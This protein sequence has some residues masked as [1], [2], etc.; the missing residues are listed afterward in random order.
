MHAITHPHTA[1][2]H[3]H[4][5]DRGIVF[6]WAW[7]AFCVFHI[8]RRISETGGTDPGLLYILATLCSLI[9]LLNPRWMPAF[10]LSVV[11][12][13]A[14]TLQT[15]PVNSNHTF[16][17]IFLL[18][19]M[20][21]ALASILLRRRR[22]LHMTPG[23]FYAAFAPYGKMMLVIMYF[24]GVFHKLNTDF[25]NPDTSCAVTLWELYPLPFGLADARWAH[26]LAIYAALIIEAAIIVML[27]VPRW[28]YAGVMLGLIFHFCL[29]V[30]GYRFFVAFSS[31]TFALHFLFL[32]EDFMARLRGSRLGRAAARHRWLYPALIF[33][34]LAAYM[35]VLTLDIASLYYATVAL[36]IVFTGSVIVG[37]GRYARSRVWRYEDSWRGLGGGT[38]LL[39]VLST[40]FFINCAMP[41]LGLKTQQN[42]NMFSNLT[43]ERGQTNHLLFGRPPYMFEFQNDLVRILR[44]NHPYF[45][46]V[47][48]EELLIPHL[49]FR[50]LIS[51]MPAEHLAALLVMYER[52]GVVHFITPDHVSDPEVLRPLSPWL[53]DWFHF[54]YV[55]TR[56]P[57]VCEADRFP[58]GREPVYK[59]RLKD[60]APTG[61][62]A[63][64]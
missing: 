31:M 33:A 51:T 42:L 58:Q 3:R 30:N 22:P 40:L 9:A 2:D 14:A 54:Q 36:F 49:E 24:Y 16:M 18:T 37:V 59:G 20:T 26:Y 1:A 56:G 39:H 5:D 38:P 17:R 64:D 52:D 8:A 27:F 55:P 4:L 45:R 6:I 12:G 32:P 28:K 47:R 15:M 11:L 53:R 23:D 25:L 57:Q 62:A 43:T 48:D 46:I 44:T 21:I 13:L 50:R 60:R 7:S 61:G 63:T 10:A 34:P 41:Y 29:G 19:G 35:L